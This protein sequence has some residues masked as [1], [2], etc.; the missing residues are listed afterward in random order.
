MVD[1]SQHNLEKSLKSQPDDRQIIVPTGKSSA[2]KTD[3][4]VD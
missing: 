4:L 1:L 3:W 2:D